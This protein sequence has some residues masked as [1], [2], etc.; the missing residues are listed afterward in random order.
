MENKTDCVCP[1][2]GYCNRHG[3]TKSA[4]LHRLCQTNQRY[5]DMWENCRGPGQ[6]TINCLQ[7]KEPEPVQESEPI[8]EEHEQPKLPS[9]ISQAKNFIQS[10]TKH[11]ADG[12]TEV[13]QETLR[14]RLEI[15]DG[16]EFLIRDSMRCGACGCFLNAKAKWRTSS[17]PKNKW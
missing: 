10:A 11:I 2:A 9:L 12:G 16:C 13:D 5:F 14:Q 8:K 7:K 4:H 1:L 17:C 3:V 6:Q 15:C